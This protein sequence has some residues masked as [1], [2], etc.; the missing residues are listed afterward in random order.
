VYFGALGVIN[1]TVRWRGTRAHSG[2]PW[3]G[4]NA[5]TR[6]IPTLERLSS[7]KPRK[8]INGG[9]EFTEVLSVTQLRTVDN[10]RNIIPDLVEANINIRIA[11]GTT[12]D[13]GRGY[14]EELV[15]GEAEIDIVDEA[16]SAP[17]LT[18][19]RMVDR[20]VSR[21]GLERR[22]MPAYT[23]VAVFALHGIPAI[24]FGPGLISQA[25]KRG[26]YV[27]REH[28]DRFHTWMHEFLVKGI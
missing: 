6:S 16:P 25:H 19:N 8:I 13:A 24:N 12:T 1:A 28:L 7:F 11:T 22:A 5:I 10:A 2:S 20:L 27:V 26:E 21:Y 3:L 23:D 9:F 18:E 4:Q 17:V 15:K 14:L